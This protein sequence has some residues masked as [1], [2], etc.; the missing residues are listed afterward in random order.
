MC[1]AD[2]LQGGACFE[3]NLD[4]HFIED[5][6]FVVG[7]VTDVKDSFDA[8]DSSSGIGPVVNGLSEFL[9]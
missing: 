9:N 4:R 1:F 7:V 5:F 8:A 6:S 3:N 2:F